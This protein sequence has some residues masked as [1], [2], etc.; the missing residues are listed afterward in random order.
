MGRMLGAFRFFAP[1]PAAAVIS[2][3]T[4][5]CPATPTT[6]QRSHRSSTVY[7]VD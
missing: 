6:T 5:D 4:L 2:H 1:L 7:Y 3:S